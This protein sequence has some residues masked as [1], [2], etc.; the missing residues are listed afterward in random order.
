VRNDTKCST[1]LAYFR[2]L[3]LPC[4]FA[5]LIFELELVDDEH[6]QGNELSLKLA[7]AHHSNRHAEAEAELVEC[8]FIS[9]MKIWAVTFDPA[10]VKSDILDDV[11]HGP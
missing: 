4:W 7:V 6:P 1:R 2:C 10:A 11:W 9:P 5:I 8:N 3:S